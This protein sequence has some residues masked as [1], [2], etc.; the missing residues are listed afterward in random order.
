MIYTTYLIIIKYYISYL[1]NIK[2]S[3][4]STH[5]YVYS[6]FVPNFYNLGTWEHS[7]EQPKHLYIKGIWNLFPMFLTVLQKKT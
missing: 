3:P 7:C 5:L 4:Y 2:S 1:I 6:H